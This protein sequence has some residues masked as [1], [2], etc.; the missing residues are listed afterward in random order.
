MSTQYGPAWP[1]AEESAQA[2][3]HTA[4][5]NADPA[6]RW[7]SVKPPRGPRPP[8]SRPGGISPKP[9]ASTRALRPVSKPGRTT[10][11]EGKT[12]HGR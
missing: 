3:W 6:Q 2:T 7:L 1:T 12:D 5:I 4:Q 9:K 8:P 10:T 11:T